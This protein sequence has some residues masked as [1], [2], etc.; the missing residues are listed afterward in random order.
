MIM[1]QWILLK[2]SKSLENLREDCDALGISFQMQDD[3]LDH[4][5]FLG[6]DR[7]SDIANKKFSIVLKNLL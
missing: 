1:V 4:Y 3:Y 5:G 7:A 6:K 2:I